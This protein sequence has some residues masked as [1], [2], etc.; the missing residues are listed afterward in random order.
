MVKQ[1]HDAPQHIF[2]RVKSKRAELCAEH[3]G[4]VYIAHPQPPMSVLW[5][6]VYY[7]GGSMDKDGRYP[8]DVF[9]QMWVS[10]ARIEWREEAQDGGR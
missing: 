7:A 10:Q 4:K 9:M 6:T 1:G 3:N 8:L 5:E 2:I